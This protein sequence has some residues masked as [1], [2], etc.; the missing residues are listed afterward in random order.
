MA[1][2]DHPLGIGQPLEEL[3]ASTATPE[4]MRGGQ[5]PGAQLQLLDREDLAAHRPQA[6]APPLKLLRP[7]DE[8]GRRDRARRRSEPGQRPPEG[9]SRHSGPHASAADPAGRPTRRGRSA[10]DPGASTRRTPACSRAVCR[11]ILCAR[12]DMPIF[13]RLGRARSVVP[14]RSRGRLGPMTRPRRLHHSSHAPHSPHTR[15]AAAA[16]ASTTASAPWRAR[17]RCPTTQAERPAPPGPVGDT[18]QQCWISRISTR[19]A[20]SPGAPSGTART[21]RRTF[22]DARAPLPRPQ[23]RRAL[24]ERGSSRRRRLS[25]HDAC[26]LP[27]LI[28]MDRV[29]SY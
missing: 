15:P 7:A 11:R 13:P 12:A 22:D 6:G 8:G 29:W 14:G 25:W 23:A 27:C 20:T 9:A 4:L 26:C 5:R 19:G 10:G 3:I 21:R 24:G 16:S 18:P 1:A 2:G 17:A 28:A